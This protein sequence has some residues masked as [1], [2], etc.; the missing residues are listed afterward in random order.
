MAIGKAGLRDGST[1]T[2]GGP[3][4]RAAT[5]RSSS[6]RAWRAWRGPDWS[7]RAAAPKAGLKRH[8]LARP[9]AGRSAGELFPCLACAVPAAT[10]LVGSL[11]PPRGG[12]DA[13]ACRPADH[14]RVTSVDPAAR[15]CRDAVCSGFVDGLKVLSF[16]PPPRR[17]AAMPGNA[18]RGPQARRAK[19]ARV[20][21]ALAD[22]MPAEGRAARVCRLRPG[23]S[24]RSPSSQR[25]ARVG[26]LRPRPALVQPPKAAI[27]SAAD[28][29]LMLPL[30]ATG[31]S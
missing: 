2:K 18:A 25:E 23:L 26:A 20:P 13:V 14:L 29:R 5:R 12:P 27:C 1:S 6:G 28:L 30:A 31:A 8:D 10:R 17:A 9:Y 4:P 3:E 15:R 16:H 22:G 7:G 19:L 21:S 24:W 11:L